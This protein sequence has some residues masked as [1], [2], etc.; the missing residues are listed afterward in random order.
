MKL[1]HWSTP[2][3]YLIWRGKGELCNNS[4]LLWYFGPESG[5]ALHQSHLKWCKPFS[6]LQWP[7]CW[8]TGLHKKSSDSVSH[9]ILQLSNQQNSPVYYKHPQSTVVSVLDFSDKTNNRCQ[10]C[11][12]KLV[13]LWDWPRLNNGYQIV[14]R[15]VW[16]SKEARKG[17]WSPHLTIPWLRI[18]EGMTV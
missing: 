13:Q 3:W 11:L 16:E 4:L 15:I 5:D 14:F 7:S 10:K 17:S 18:C 2:H 6:G 12:W 1:Q 8:C 9:M